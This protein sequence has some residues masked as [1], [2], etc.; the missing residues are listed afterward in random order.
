MSKIVYVATRVSSVPRDGAIDGVNEI[1]VIGPRATEVSAEHRLIAVDG[2]PLSP[3]VQ[4]LVDVLWK[5]VP[6]RTIVRITPAD[7]SRRFFAAVRRTRGI[8]AAIRD[9]DVIVAADR[10]ALW[11]TWNLARRARGPQAVYG[12]SA[13]KFALNIG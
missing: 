13:A 7:R 10:D 5:S 8:V 1:T 12:I 6:G 4:K 11:A 3:P 2:A 9:A